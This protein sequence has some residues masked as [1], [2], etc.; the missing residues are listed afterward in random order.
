[1]DVRF[2]FQEW[3]RQGCTSVLL[4]ILA[5]L[6]ARSLTGMPTWPGSHQRSMWKSDAVSLAYREFVR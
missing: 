3:G 2:K 6:S 4:A 1:M 5:A